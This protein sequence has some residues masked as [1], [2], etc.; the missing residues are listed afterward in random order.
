M[1]KNTVVGFVLI[2]ILL[3]TWSYVNRPSAEEMERRAFVQDSI[4]QAQLR[5]DSLKEIGV[6]D[7]ITE[8]TEPEVQ[9][10]VPDSI[11]SL[12][13]SQEFGLFAPSA[14]GSE[15][16]VVLE[17]DVLRLVFNTKGGFIKEAE[18][19]EYQKFVKDSTKK[20][21]KVPLKL[22]E[23]PENKFEYILPTGSAAGKEVVS[24]DLY[25]TP[26][27]SGNSLSL[28]APTSNGGY[29]EQVYTIEDGS[30]M[31][32][33]DLRFKNLDK[34]IS[35][36]NSDINL[37]WVNLL[38]KLEKNAQYES[39]YST[40]YFKE[41]EEDPSW[42]NCRKTS[43]KSPDKP[44]KWVGNTQQFFT[45]TLIADNNF[46][47]AELA[48]EVFDK[49]HESLKKLTSEITFPYAHGSDETFGMRLYLGPNKYKTLK[50][51]DLDMEDMIAFGWSIFGWVNRHIIRPLFNFLAGFISSYGIAILVLTFLVK[52]ALFPLTYRM[53]YS[54]S[55][56]QAL[57]PQLTKLKEKIGDDAQKMQ[58][59]QMKL[60]R[61]TGVSPLGGCMPMILQMPIWFALY[62]FFPAS[63]E[64]RQK[65]FLWADDL[66]SFDSIMSIGMDIPMFG[67]HISLFT[68]LWAFTTVIYSYYNSK[69]MD[70]SAQPM[71]KY[72]QYF[73]P[74]MFIVFFNSYASGLTC[75]LFFSNIFNITQTVVT[76]NFIIDQEKV[77]AEL[78]ANKKK[79]K[80][81]GGFQERLE[82]AMKEQQAKKAKME[83]DKAKE[84]KATRKK[85]KK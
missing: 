45:S 1:D 38:S 32:D 64:F 21:S 25:F 20:Y 2:F 5:I 12:V 13:L 77:K 75:Y 39:M 10:E 57:K 4:K 18:L 54:Q 7:F 22:L 53:L 69:H 44:I 27:L 9:I 80:K 51:Y 56:M 15:E 19:K 60:Y 52:L 55:K 47:K 84:N 58:M 83:M 6:T 14:S 85:S 16:D 65:G 36:S 17:N 62:R 78:E 40:V 61:E 63:I 35:R 29:L 50:Q 72:I 8:N 26:K 11:K 68:L 24:S 59:E 73:M 23:N 43:T 79:P 34:V 28:R 48:T 3:M 33:Y 49:D 70:F 42:C 67:S 71:M 46:S 81:K 30:Y 31:I 76:K 82:Q 66:S 37:K 74:I 41:A